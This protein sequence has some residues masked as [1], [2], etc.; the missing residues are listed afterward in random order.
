MAEEGPV[1]PSSPGFGLTGPSL[2]NLI[3]A[4]TGCHL[5]LYMECTG[6]ISIHQSLLSSAFLINPE[7]FPG[8]TMNL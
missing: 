4:E 6:G 1:D 2:S 7:L 8:T 5:K 3:P